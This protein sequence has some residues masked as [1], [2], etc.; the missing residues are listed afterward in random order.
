MM[1]EQAELVELVQVFTQTLSY[2]S[3]IKGDNKKMSKKREEGF[4]LWI[5]MFGVGEETKFLQ[6]NL[7]NLRLQLFLKFMVVGG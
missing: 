3:S 4:K 2:F 5:K 6:P 7:Q 1:R